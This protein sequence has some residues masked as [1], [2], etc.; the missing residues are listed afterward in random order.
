[1]ATRLTPWAGNVILLPCQTPDHSL[2]HLSPPEDP[3]EAQAIARAHLMAEIDEKIGEVRTDALDLT[4][5][6]I[7]N[8]KREDEIKIDPEYQRLFRWV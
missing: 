2:A 1:M 4:F 7:I 6:E 8:L 3:A 5:G